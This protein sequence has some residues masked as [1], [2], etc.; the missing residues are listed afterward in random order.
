MDERISEE[1]MSASEAR[2]ILRERGIERGLDDR[3]SIEEIAT[4]IIETGSSMVRETVEE[5]ATTVVE[6]SGPMFRQ[7]IEVIAVDEASQT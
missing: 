6:V 4:T 2:R 5:T 1:P 3:R 7:A